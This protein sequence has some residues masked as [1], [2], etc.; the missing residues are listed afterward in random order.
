M[1]DIKSMRLYTHLERISN[2][3]GEIGKSLDDQ[4]TVNDLSAFDQLHYHG[5][6]ALDCAIDIL[7][8]KPQQ[9]WLE[10][11]SGLG[12]PAR[13]LADKAGVNL[14]ALELQDDQN[15]LAAKL[16]RQCNL[17]NLIDHQCGDFLQANFSSEQFDAVVSWLAIYHIPNRPLL[18]E[19][20]RDALKAGGLF[21]TEDLFAR[22]PFS[23]DEREDLEREL[24]ATTLPDL[25]TYQSQF[26]D[27]GF[28]IIHLE[29]MSDDWSAFTHK[30]L[31]TYHG[32]R[33]RHVRVNGETVYNAL[34]QF[35]SAVDRHFQTGKLGGIRLCAR[36]K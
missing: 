29:D 14:V 4:L 13:Y 8:A 2:E 20:S 33:E 1:S 23:Q 12:G 9:N 7:T 25:E 21:Y 34:N 26:D 36:K 10:I 32:D 30:R 17:E 18:L 35:Y 15:D 5:T 22:Q 27:A 31:D 16:T 28:E 6:A 3:L 11:G 24:Y 19:K